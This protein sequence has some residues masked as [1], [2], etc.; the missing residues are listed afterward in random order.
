MSRSF[1]VLLPV[2]VLWAVLGCFAPTHTAA[3]S[4]TN[5]PI[6]KPN[7]VD[8]C[9]NVSIPFPF[10]LTPDCY[11]N[12]D[13]LIN[14]STSTNGSRKPLL[15]QSN[16]DII[17]ISVE[18][19]LSAMNLVA[20]TCDKDDLSAWVSFSLSKFYI[21]QTANKFVAVG[22]NTIAIISGE[23]GEKSYQTGC[24]ASCN[25]F[26]D[27]VNG[28]CNGIGCCQTTDMPILSSSVN[29]KLQNMTRNQYIVE[30][31]D[32]VYCSYAFVVKKDEFNFSS[33]MLT[34]KWQGEK[35]P[36]V[37]DWMVSKD[38][39]NSSSVCKGNTTCENYPGPDG[40]YRCYCNKG[41]QGNPYLHPGCLDIDECG[42]DGQNNCTSKNATCLNTLGGYNCT[43]KEG[44]IGDGKVGCQLPIKDECKDNGKGC[45]SSSRVNM[46][47]LDI[48]ECKGK[49]NCSKNS[50]CINTEGGYECSCM[51]GYHGDGMGALGCTV[52]SS[53]HQ[54]IGLVLGIAL[55]TIALLI[56]V[57]CVYLGYRR[58]KSI[59]IK[60]KFFMEN[61]GLILQ[62][63]IAKGSAS[64][65]TT[66]IF[67]TEDLKRATNN[68]DQTRIIGQGGFGIVYK[69]HLLDGQIIAVKK[70]KMMDPTQVEQFINENQLFKILDNNIVCEENTEE[71]REVALLAKKCLNVKGEDR[72]M[73]KEVAV[74]LSGLRR[75]AK[76]P[77]TNNSETSMESEALLMSNQSPSTMIL[78]SI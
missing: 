35:L 64:S 76:H 9:G 63:K 23:E 13:F 59:L 77:W 5:Y 40:G 20:R 18:G 49:N 29:L 39:C 53:N 30:E 61:G 41:Y 60:E 12:E 27:V 22:C 71:L 38:K 75:A 25:R 10:G 72:P 24:I 70:A 52:I 14:C 48:D 37:I 34:K 66:R 7:C 28:N 73:M 21:N 42:D 50:I 31:D 33:N 56:T 19:Q 65:G 69:G 1:L 67:T 6:A 11:L 74:E 78:H 54:S 16:I 26:Q 62:Q 58:R 51:K 17:T 15:R 47:S 36:L 2:L 45:H 46:I 4:K 44:Y 32:A 43:C 68:Y 3:T 57:F 8:H 55:G